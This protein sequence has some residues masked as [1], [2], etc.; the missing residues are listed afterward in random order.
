MT[1]HTALNVLDLSEQNG[2]WPSVPS[3]VLILDLDGT[4]RSMPTMFSAR[5]AD[6]QEIVP[7]VLA[8]AWA[9]RLAGWIICA[10]TN[11]SGIGRGARS[12]DEVIHTLAT[13]DRLCGGLFAR[14]YFCPHAP[15]EDGMPTCLCRKPRPGMLR[16]ALAGNPKGLMIGDRSEDRGAALNASIEYLDVAQFAPYRQSLQMNVWPEAPFDLDGPARLVWGCLSGKAPHTSMA[17]GEIY[18]SFKAKGYELRPELSLSEQIKSIANA[19]WPVVLW[20]G[21]D[22]AMCL[23]GWLAIAYTLEASCEAARKSLVILDTLMKHTIKP[24]KNTWRCLQ[25]AALER[26]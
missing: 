26:L 20:A 11:Q 1:S 19:A 16:A 23:A 21:S 10:A 8:Q 3:G 12:R 7:A 5:T 9:W 13:T 18:Q 4:L 24:K 2:P 6:S 14:M 22:H 25:A 15:T 17:R